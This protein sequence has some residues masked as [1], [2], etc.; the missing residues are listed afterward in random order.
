MGIWAK[1]WA[2]ACRPISRLTGSQWADKFRVVASG[3]SPEA[4]SWRTSRTPYLQEPMDSATDRRTEIVVMCCSSQLGKS[5]MLLNIMGYYAD[6]EP[7][8]TADR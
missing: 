1:A 5:E 4:G 2:Q 6:Q 8:A 7:Y 3:T